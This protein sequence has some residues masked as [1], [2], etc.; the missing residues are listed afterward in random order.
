MHNKT[1]DIL[2]IEDNQAHAEI[3][4]RHFESLEQQINLIHASDG[5]E[6]LDYLYG[7]EYNS[8]PNKK[9]KPQLI[10]L[11]LR[12]PKIDG[13]EVLKTIKSDEKLKQIP[14]IVLTTSDAQTDI[15]L[16]YK[17]HANSY[18][19]KQIDFTKFVEQMECASKYWLSYNRLPLDKGKSE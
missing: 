15:V 11:D 13:L 16:A 3:V 18:L 17:Y 19:V 5:Q 12:L 9:K 4:I 8:Q 1:I 2:L 14:V 7:K 10:F 6:A